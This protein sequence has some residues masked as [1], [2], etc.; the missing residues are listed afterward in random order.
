L[1]EATLGFFDR[2]PVCARQ[3]GGQTDRQTQ[4]HGTYHASI[5]SRGK[6]SGMFAIQLE[7]SKDMSFFSHFHSSTVSAFFFCGETDS[8]NYV[9][10]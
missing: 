5:T 1:R 10:Q 7:E 2:T 8:N 9:N 3:T 6:N 4:G